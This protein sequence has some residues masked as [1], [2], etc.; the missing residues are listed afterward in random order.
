MN[1][2]RKSDEPIV[3]AT[4]ANKGAAE[5]PEEPAEERGSAKRN[6]E[7]SAS[8]R[9]PSRTSCK[10]R[11]LYGVRE[12]FAIDSRQEPYEVM[13]HVRICAGGRR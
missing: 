13:L 9:T 1:A 10:S 12:D 11:G 3:P 4:S 6:A 8:H 5:T 2:N 7:Q